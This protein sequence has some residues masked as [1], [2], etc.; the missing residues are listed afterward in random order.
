MN[1]YILTIKKEDLM[2]FKNNTINDDIYILGEELTS[3]IKD[4]YG[5]DLLAI[6]VNHPLIFQN[7]LIKTYND[8]LFCIPY[9]SHNYNN[10]NSITF[11]KPFKIYKIKIN[12]R[13]HNELRLATFYISN[14]IYYNQLSFYNDGIEYKLKD[15]QPKLLTDFF[16]KVGKTQK[17]VFD[18]FENKMKRIKRILLRDNIKLLERNR[19][20]LFL[21]RHHAIPSKDIEYYKYPITSHEA[22]YSDIYN[23]EINCKK[24]ANLTFTYKGFDKYK[25]I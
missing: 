15:Y 19:I 9:H 7:Q 4:V 2:K 5:Y 25:R 6:E 22:T 10:Y 13:L 1:N 14:N 3:E 21:M 8:Y 16:Q 11:M 20:V 18:G 12:I 17:Q 24:D 23:L